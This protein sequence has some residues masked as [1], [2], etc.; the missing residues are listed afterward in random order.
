MKKFG[1]QSIGLIAPIIREGDNLVEIVVDTI[2]HSGL[3]I[4]DNE[5]N[6]IK[7]RLNFVEEDTLEF[8][9]NSDEQC[10]CAQHKRHFDCISGKH[11]F[12]ISYNQHIRPCFNIWESEGPWFDASLSMREAL[13]K[14]ES[15]LNEKKNEVIEYCSGCKAHRFCSECMM[16]QNKNKS[17]LQ[18]YMKDACAK[19]MIKFLNYEQRKGR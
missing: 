18:E 10:D 7:S 2:L 11:T 13:L 6:E 4:E 16:T 12:A 3:K 15:Y 14:M 8:S 19:N 9:Q 1:V 5:F 17:R